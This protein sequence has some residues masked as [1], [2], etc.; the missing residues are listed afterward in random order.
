MDINRE[1]T[2]EERVN[3][4]AYNRYEMRMKY[5]WWR[6]NDT[7]ED[8]WR[9]GRE[10]AEKDYKQNPDSTRPKENSGSDK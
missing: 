3:R 8:D 7:R 4:Y 1:E 5:P 9:V 6:P 2:F 10:L